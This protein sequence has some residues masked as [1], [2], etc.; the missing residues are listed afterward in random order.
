MFLCW[1]EDKH[2]RPSLEMIIERVRAFR[3]SDK[4]ASSTP[5]D[6]EKQKV[7]HVKLEEAIEIGQA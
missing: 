4:S 2:D 6:N 7:S 1:A 3:K 5:L